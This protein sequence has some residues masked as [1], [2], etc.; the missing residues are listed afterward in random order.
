[1]STRRKAGSKDAGTGTTLRSPVTW[2]LLGIVIER[3]GYAHEFVERFERAYGDALALSSA[4][5]VYVSLDSL[6][7]RS[8][9]KEMPSNPTKSSAMRQPRPRYRATPKGER[10]YQAWLISQAR[11]QRHRSRLFTLQIAAL[12]PNAALKIIESYELESL[13]RAHDL[14]PVKRERPDHD[15]RELLTSRLVNEEERLALDARLS[16]IEYARRELRAAVN[17][18]KR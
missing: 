1:M 8:L 6:T 13:Q 9:I 17:K 3:P 11:E 5:Q 4:S 2:A 14:N 15:S 7:S 18:G 12:H 10:A 16:W